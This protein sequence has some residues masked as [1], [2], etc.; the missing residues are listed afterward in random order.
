MIVNYIHE[1]VSLCNKVKPSNFITISG[2]MISL[3]LIN[4]LNIFTS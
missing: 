4:I 1:T 2:T 3:K